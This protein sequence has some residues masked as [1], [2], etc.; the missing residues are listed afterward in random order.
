M[1]RAITL[2]L[3]FGLLV[4]Q[5]C[6][7]Q[8]PV[9]G[10]PPFGSFGGGPF[11]TINL[12]N[13]NV[14]FAVPVLNKAGR[15][16][17]FSYNLSYDSSVWYPVGTVGSQTWTPV[18]NWGWM[19]QTA[20]H[21]GYVS[22]TFRL[23]N[24]DT[25]G[26]QYRVWD[27]FVYVDPWG[28]SHT[29]PAG[30][31]H[32][33]IYDPYDCINGGIFNYTGGAKDGSGLSLSASI[34]TKGALNQSK[35]TARN[36]TVYNPPYYAGGASTVT[37]ANGNQISV[38]NGV[39]T[40]TLGTTALT[41]TGTGPTYLKYTAQ[42]GST[43]YTINYQSYTVATA[44]GISG[45]TEYPKTANSLVDNI[46]VPG[47]SQYKFT[48]EKTPG[49]CT[50]LSGTYSG[51]CVTARIASVTLPSG[52]QISYS[53]SGGHYGIESDGSTAGLS[54]IT[55]DSGTAWTYSRSLSGSTWV[56]TVVDPQ[57][58][59]TV[60]NFAK[61]SS[62]GLP[63]N[64]FYELQ[65]QA[66][67]G[68]ISTSNLLLTTFH[69]YN[70]NL[71]N[72]ATQAV[73]SPITQL[74][75]YLKW[76]NG[77]QSHS[78]TLYDSVS[79]LE[80]TDNEYDYGG[81]KLSNSTFAYTYLG[82]NIGYRPTCVQVTAGT[83]PS[84]CGTI[85]SDTV[86]ATDYTNYDSAGNVKT[87]SQWVAGVTGS[88]WLSRGFTYTTG[89]LVQTATDVNG[90]QVSYTYAAN[91]NCPADSFP[92][93]VAEPLNLSRSMTW[94]CNGGVLASITN[95]S[96]NTINYSYG[97]PLW[98]MTEVSNPDGG[99]TTTTYNTGSSFPWTVSTCATMVTGSTC[100]GGSTNVITVTNLDG[101]GRTIQNQ[102]T[103]DPAGTDY[104][105]TTYDA[106]GRVYSV[107][108]P[109]HAQ[110]DYT[111]GVTSYL[112]DALSR[113]TTI[114]NPDSTSRSISYSS[115]AMQTT[116]ERNIPVVYQYDGFGRM[117]SA[118]VG[119]NANQQ[120]N[121]DSAAAC[122][123]DITASGFLATYG[124]S[125]IGN[126][127]SVSYRAQTRQY[128]YD[129]LSRLTS[130]TNPE[131]G[132]TSYSY[133]L[134]G[135]QGDL[136]QRT[137]PA[138]NQNQ[139]NTATTTYSFDLLHRL[140]GKS[141]TG[142]NSTPTVTLKYDVADSTWSVTQS[143]ILGQL[144]SAWVGNTV[145]SAFSYDK[146]GRPLNQWQCTPN[147]QC[148]GTGSVNSIAQ[149]D[150]VGDL[151]YVRVGNNDP[152]G[153][154]F[155]ATPHVIAIKDTYN[156]NLS[157]MY[158]IE[159]NGLE[160]PRN[161]NLADNNVVTLKYD[162]FGGLTSKSVVNGSVT[163]YNLGVSYTSDHNVLTAN[164]SVN[165]NWRYV[166]S[167]AFPQR[168]GSSTCS[169][170]CPNGTS[171]ESHA[172]T[173]DEFANRWSQT[174]PNGGPNFIY[175]FNPNNQITSGASVVYDAA[176]NMTT[177]EIGNTYTYDDENRLAAIGGPYYSTSYNFD[178]FG[179]RVELT[180]LSG[181]KDLFYDVAGRMS[182]QGGSQP[183]LAESISGASRSRP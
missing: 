35:V 176:G 127:T 38:S 147:T 173:Y 16:M 55:P 170:G 167:G 6:F 15:G 46:Q 131:S 12:G 130:E 28:T 149:Y 160:L 165:G 142:G 97:D 180:N 140:T 154:T 134:A 114:T 105:D 118:C 49:S 18:F 52:G 107:S 31:G 79:G 108:N 177:D 102:L 113:V 8:G 64:N 82:S 162:Q 78:Q 73:A 58:N 175:T 63:T 125:A 158:N 40:D 90:A 152:V 115:R 34:T 54:R 94:D 126:M 182:Y 61:D 181:Y 93:S 45:I 21:T 60:I 104:V 139:G 4:V 53:Y 98:R 91:N 133:D 26:E 84:S 88:K 121:G 68:A 163:T 138:P 75:A 80:T 109:Y 81:T 122:N 41:V 143:N 9:T 23:V 172:Y 120:A 65:R 19:A 66:Y 146:M 101:L 128:Q 141:Y 151:T 106:L 30:L 171:T 25:Q 96:N 20:V 10:T 67:Q 1:N 76:P 24:C 99:V 164:D 29:Y 36:G 179:R 83:V 103:S 50:P 48:Y 100:P 7:G 3:T 74:D 117:A 124:Y 153:Y 110:S 144:S 123:Q 77:S 159:Y 145:S 39:F 57:L 69:C 155:D 166:Y 168:L 5:V 178:A 135:Q 132:T 62:T 22:Y 169:L 157:Y 14:H 33:L 71:T 27:N 11:D 174:A 136:Y 89:G 116:N 2:V 156:S 137:R 161:E 51:Y 56:T 119:V 47:G 42:T 86:S 148:N 44:F 95:E 32:Q 150:Y 72:C 70:N 17:P 37:D 112:Y 87:I 43:E 111:Y 183:R 59:N 85:T 92:S 129:G 13:L